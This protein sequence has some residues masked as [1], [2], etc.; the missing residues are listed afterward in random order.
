M[1]IFFAIYLPKLFCQV[2]LSGLAFPL[3]LNQSLDSIQW[4]MSLSFIE[5]RSMGHAIKFCHNPDTVYCQSLGYK[6]RQ[7]NQIQLFLH[8]IFC[9]LPLIMNILERH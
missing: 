2:E 1:R 8:Q 7:S 4:V 6:I 5:L 3:P 9:Q